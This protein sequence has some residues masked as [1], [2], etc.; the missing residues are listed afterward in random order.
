MRIFFRFLFVF[1]RDIERSDIEGILLFNV[2]TLTTVDHRA[3]FKIGDG[4]PHNARLI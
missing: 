1:F 4:K 3:H 2:N